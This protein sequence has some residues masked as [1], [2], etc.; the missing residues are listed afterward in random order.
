VAR[1]TTFA[2]TTIAAF[3]TTIAAFATTVA[4]FAAA[5]AT[6]AA[7]ATGATLPTIAAT[8]TGAPAPGRRTLLSALITRTVTHDGCRSASRIAADTGRGLNIR[9][10]LVVKRQ[11][12]GISRRRNG[13]AY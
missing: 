12:S 11:Q 9:P 2:T 1:I 10:G 4:T 13:F 3:A 7:F 6:F 5:I 8:G